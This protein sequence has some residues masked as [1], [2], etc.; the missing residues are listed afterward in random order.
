MKNRRKA[1]L[2]RK[3]H[4][5]PLPKP[6]TGLGE[7]IKRDIPGDFTYTTDQDRNRFTMFNAISLRVAAS[8]LVL[9]GGAYFAISMLSER[10]KPRSAAAISTI[11][12]PTE[13]PVPA[14]AHR[15]LDASR[16]IQ[17]TEQAAPPAVAEAKPM[18][19][20]VVTDALR[21]RAKAKKQEE[22]QPLRR[23]EE[24]QSNALFA[25]IAND[26]GAA[27]VT[28]GKLAA[29]E[30][31]PAADGEKKDVDATSK[32]A[33]LQK[34]DQAKELARPQSVASVSAP[35]PPPPAAAPMAQKTAETVTV[36]AEAP[37]LDV[38]RAAAG[39]SLEA[40]SHPELFGIST[41]HQAF[42]RIKASIEHGDR[43]AADS[44]DVGALVNYFAGPPERTHHAVALDLEASTRPVRDGKPTALV[45]VSVDT[46]ETIYDAKLD[47]VFDHVS[48]ASYHR[49]DGGTVSSAAEPVMY[50]NRSVTTL[51]EVELRPH[52]RALQAV[53]TV[54]LAYRGANGAQTLTRWVSYSEAQMAWKTRSRRHRLATLG[55]I[56][57]ET[58]RTSA[59]GQ[60][61]AATA[62]QLS[63]QEPKDEK[64][65]ELATL[66]T[67]SSRL[68]SSSPTGSGR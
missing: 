40:P 16:D 51:Y 48:V 20:A 65:K 41:D 23:D 58:L 38:K 64:A 19:V 63:K 55:A 14:V 67:A 3:L 5:A 9:I 27:G 7:R 17:M 24:A 35:P 46:E 39:A 52:V 15:E 49:V 37:L 60:D 47:I 61:V 8:I 6:P 13:A 29:N 68:R 33:E 30:Q 32:V 54:T 18:Q 34:T 56:W 50:A 43:P 42:D 66:A 53:A 62:E 44:V 2:Q 22:N 1:E 45:R 11:A 4:A 10:Q 12:L 25:G 57:A 36:T 31:L 59:A 21:T 26:K 28:G